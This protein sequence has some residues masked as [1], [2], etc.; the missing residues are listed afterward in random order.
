[1]KGSIGK[2]MNFSFS[3]IL[4]LV[5]VALIVVVVVSNQA[6]TKSKQLAEEKFPQM[7]KMDDLKLA[8]Y[9]KRVI[10]DQYLTSKKTQILNEINNRD[11]EIQKTLNQI[12]YDKKDFLKLYNEYNKMF[13]DII[14][15]IKKNPTKLSAAMRKTANADKFF[16]EK[17]V[18]VI[19]KML[20]ENQ[21][22]TDNLVNQI[23]SSLKSSQLI[24]IIIGIVIIILG[25]A[26]S[27]KLTRGLTTPIKSLTKLT[28]KISMGDFETE[29]NI[30]TGDEIEELA[31]SIGRM[32]KSLQ[33]AMQRLM[34]K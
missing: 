22:Q 16:S 24:F 14:K 1:M 32:K 18:P 13:D 31:E 7:L 28:D 17:L 23:Q 6:L 29:I 3:I 4:F 20:K 25:Y 5:I 9:G 8:I 2:K 26:L 27:S 33:K 21:K 19:D 34:N 15:F 30:K 10:F 11:K 12:K